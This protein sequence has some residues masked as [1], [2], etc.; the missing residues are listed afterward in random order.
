MNQAEAN[1]E[2]NL[3]ELLFRFWAY[4]FLFFVLIFVFV[5]SSIVYISITPKVY[6]S[7]SI[8]IPENQRSLNYSLEGAFSQLGAFGQLAGISPAASKTDALIERFTGREFVL[9]L[10]HELKL[11]DDQFFNSYDPKIQEPFWK[12]KLKSLIYG[13]S[14]SLNPAQI[15]DWNLLE[16]FKKSVR[17]SETSGGAIRITSN[18]FDPERAAEI[19]NHIMHKIVSVLKSEKIQDANKRLNYLSLN[20]ADSLI[21]FEKTEENLKQFM[22][23]NNTAAPEAFYSG[24]IKLDNLRT[25][26]GD[27]K[28]QIN[29]IDVLLSYASRSVPTRQDYESLRNKYPYLD[30]SDFRRIL[31]ISEIISAWSWPSVETLMRTRTSIQDRISSLETEIRKYEKEAI[32]YATSAEELNRLKREMKIAEATYKVLVEQSKIQSLTAGFTPDTSQIIA[33]AQ[34]AITETKPNRFLIL[35][36]AATFGFFAAAL[37]TLIL[38]LKKGVFYSSGELL[39]AIKPKYYHKIRSLHYYRTNNLKEVQNRLIKRPIPWL[40]QV[41][42]ESAVSRGTSPIIVADTTNL[43]DA[44]VIARLLA[45]S[46]HEFE[47]SAAYVDLSK[48]LKIPGNKKDNQVSDS[49]I[50]I[51]VAEIINGCTE[52]NYRGGKQNVDWLFSKSFQE[53]LEFLNTRHDTVI[54]S[55]NSDILD[56]LLASKNLHEEKLVIHAS[57]GK[58]TFDNIRKLNARGN[59]EIALLS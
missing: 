45:A 39:N 56:L 38:T 17:M 37:L 7:T 8:F 12:T 30:Q 3:A 42:L 51:E 16:N 32:K 2:I 10:S 41:F 4:K 57:R 13:Q 21:S 49:K 25:Q 11:S 44:A 18:H 27:S 48:T 15:A 36:L 46:S 23:S 29:T 28:K 31:G 24:S 1:D 14:R 47:M 20:L 43:F 58:S 22:L 54:F 6:T 33:A 19:A 50:E 59:I 34:A 9:E 35:G 52:Y 55:A 5:C 53:T 40:K 26:L